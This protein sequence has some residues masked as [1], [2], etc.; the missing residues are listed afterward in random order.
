MR[1]MIQLGVLLLTLLSNSGKAQILTSEASP[2]YW[3][4]QKLHKQTYPN[5]ALLLPFHIGS[6]TVFLQLDLGMAGNVLYQPA[7]HQLESEGIHQQDGTVTLSGNL[8]QHPFREEFHIHRGVADS[9]MR[10]LRGKPIVGL[11]GLKAFEGHQLTL[12]FIHQQFTLD[13]APSKNGDLKASNINCRL[14]GHKL[15]MNLKGKGS[16]WVIYDSGSSPF[17]LIT[18]RDYWQT[19]TQKTLDNPSVRNL[20]LPA[21]HTNQKQGLR[22]A[23][24]TISQQLKVGSQPVKS[25]CT[26][27]TGSFNIRALAP[28]AR[29]VMGNQPFIG[30]AILHLDLQNVACQIFKP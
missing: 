7:L 14:A 12:D 5:A 19:L 20:T 27:T 30:R 28:D 11:I 4:S 9:Q 29:A 25:A 26:R 24:D 1:I 15:L 23:C 21:S 17:G 16:P 3:Q 22:L 10:E 8:N 18:D 13:Q 2:F 6:D